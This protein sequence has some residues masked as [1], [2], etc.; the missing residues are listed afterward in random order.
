MRVSRRMKRMGRRENKAMPMSLTS[1][2]DVFT[3]L[4][5]FLLISQ[6]V[7]NVDEPPK[8][9]KLPDSYVEAKPR[10]TV[11]ILVSDQAIMVQ[12]EVLASTAEAMAAEG[13]FIPAVKDRLEQIKATA[14]GL[15]AQTKDG[16]NEVTILA[17]SKIPFKTMKKI[18]STCTSAGYSK[19]SLAVNQKNDVVAR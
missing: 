5:F 13:D 19:I 4:V 3:N 9:I 10:P 6:G 2:M 17:N 18:M 11:N 1:L 12:G 15:N 16:N 7:T 8:E 14:I